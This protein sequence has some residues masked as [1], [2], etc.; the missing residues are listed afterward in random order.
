MQSKGPDESRDETRVAGTKHF[1]LLLLLPALLFLGFHLRTLDYGFVWTDQIEIVDGGIVLPPSELH[2][3]LVRPMVADV[4]TGASWAY[5]RPLQVITVSLIHAMAGETPRAYR[6]PSLL[7]GAATMSLFAG[8]AWIGLGRAGPALFAGMLPA[9]HPAGLEVYVWIAGLSA[10][11]V[12]LLLVG[13]L[14]CATLWLQAGSFVRWRPWLLWGCVVLYVLALLAKESAVI[15]P[16]L[17]L[18]VVAGDALAGQSPGGR[19][20]RIARLEVSMDGLF[21]AAALGAL[22]LVHIGVVRP[23]V[24]GTSGSVSPIGGSVLT[25]WSTAF[26]SWPSSLGWLLFPWESSASDVAPIVESL[27]DVRPWM[28]LCVL[29]GSV[30]IWLALARAGLTVA[31]LGVA[32][33]WIAFLPASNLL[34]TLHAK[35]ERHVFLST[36]GVA[37][38]LAQL[39]P[40]LLA[41]SRLPKVVGT[42]LAVALLAVAGQRTWART[43]DWR[44]T[45]TLFERDVARE[46]DYREGRYW[47][48]AT[49]LQEGRAAE[50]I[51]HLEILLT[52]VPGIP[53]RTSYLGGDPRLLYCHALLRTS[54]PLGAERFVRE[55]EKT[56]PKRAAAPGMQACLGTALEASEQHAGA[57]E[58]Y[59]RLARGSHPHP[60]VFVS[61]ARCHARMGEG[62][63]ARSWLGRVPSQVRGDPSI[64]YGIQEVREILAAPRPR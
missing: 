41:R 21:L 49:L 57:I 54:D 43:P 26:A 1:P 33:I 30:A 55:L 27:R 14:G 35:A 15:L 62:T 63:E 18:A 31:A 58:V 10:S 20:L 60:E 17:V 19:R 16:A 32:W 11:M 3:A 24:L 56:R 29:V 12:A 38:V 36:F 40:A 44:S 9:V 39:T 6:L 8:L 51:G 5:Y 50:A 47:L 59:S 48:G 37:L 53:G 46:P 2:H 34:P 22:A 28:G 7:I 42:V 25:H 4:A 45:I 52:Q 61:L 13:S 64:Y 23:L